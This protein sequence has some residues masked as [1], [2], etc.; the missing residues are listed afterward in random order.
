MRLAREIPLLGLGP[1]LP[2]RSKGLE[3]IFF[4]HLA[5]SLAARG[6]HAARLVTLRGAS[7]AWVED[8]TGHYG[9]GGQCPKPFGIFSAAG[10]GELQQSTCRH[11]HRRPRRNRP[12]RP[13][14]AATA[15]ID[16]ARQRERQPLPDEPDRN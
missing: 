2:I 11:P 16:A 8:C 4:C 14:A 13:A 9:G 3:K 6:L 12:S 1:A 7:D 15:A 5:P 10:A